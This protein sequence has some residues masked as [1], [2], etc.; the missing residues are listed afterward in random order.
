MSVYVQ[1]SGS[2]LVHHSILE[3]LKRT[4]TIFCENMNIW[5]NNYIIQYILYLYKYGVI[6]ID[7]KKLY[8]V[9]LDRA[10]SCSWCTNNTSVSSATTSPCLQTATAA[11]GVYDVIPHVIVMTSHVVCCLQNASRDDR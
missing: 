7:S 3:K 10:R 6:S 1:L 9:D 2:N 11:R 5:Y 8:S 4:R